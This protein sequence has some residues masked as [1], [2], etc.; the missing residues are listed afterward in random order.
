M[1]YNTLNCLMITYDSLGNESEKADTMLNRLG[2][3]VVQDVIDH[4]LVYDAAID[5]D[6][7]YGAYAKFWVI[8]DDDDDL[9]DVIIVVEEEKSTTLT[10]ELNKQNEF[11]VGD[12]AYTLKDR[13]KTD[14]NSEDNKIP[15]HKLAANTIYDDEGKLCL[16]Y[17]SRCV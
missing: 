16:L 15:E 4:Q 5:I 9:Y 1:L 14:A 17:T 7:Y 6:E 10:G 11:T 2:A 12:K 13:A 3:R 8:D